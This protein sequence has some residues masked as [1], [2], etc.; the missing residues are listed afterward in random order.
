MSGSKLAPLRAARPRRRLVSFTVAA[1]LL[2][3][4]YAWTCGD[5]R[6]DDFDLERRAANIER[7]L[8]QDIAPY[9]LRD[10]EHGFGDTLGWALGIV[11][12]RG[13]EG[14]ART[15][16]MATAAIAL[17][18]LAGWILAQFAAAT[19]ATG[20]PFGDAHGRERWSWRLLRAALAGCFVFLRAIPE[21]IWAFLLVAVLGPGAWPLVLALAI[22]N[23]GI[24]GR[25]G[26]ETLENLPPRPLSAL[27]GLGAG[28]AQTALLAAAPGSLSRYLLYV[29]YRFETCVREATVL[30]MLG[31][32][33]LG[34]WI[35]DVRTRQYYD[36]MTLLVGC[37]ALLVLAV[38]LLSAVVRHRL[39]RAG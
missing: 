35:E 22:H 27:R 37:G 19:I 13:L 5:I 16:A 38:D 32:V 3:A 8:S 17:A 30:G 21:Y 14:A 26:A 6:L 36:E 7:F 12:E 15:M 29:F 9:P 33:S 10:A 25:L 24:L 2:L 23:S 18:A 31:I 11:R 39:R 4:S 1:L 28:R 20:R 34:Y